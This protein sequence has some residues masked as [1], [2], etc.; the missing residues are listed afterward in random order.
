MRLDD[1]AN[2]IIV[3]GRKNG[4]SWADLADLLNKEGYR[5]RRKMDEYGPEDVNMYA[6]THKVVP[7]QRT[8]VA[9]DA[10]TIG[11][12]KK[13]KRRLRA[14]ADTLTAATVRGPA[15]KREAKL[16]TPRWIDEVVE[17]LS[18]NLSEA[19]KRKLLK[20]LVEV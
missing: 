4:A 11:I 15:V 14:S 17:L 20:T 16:N 6:L 9:G 18:S 2:Q 1:K 8:T 7:R 10:G 3:D 5:R 19:T 13:G 12:R